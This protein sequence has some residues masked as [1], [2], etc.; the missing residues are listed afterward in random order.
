M[1]RG[2]RDDLIALA[3]EERIGTDDD[4]ACPELG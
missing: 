1:A 4:G 3:D 2:E